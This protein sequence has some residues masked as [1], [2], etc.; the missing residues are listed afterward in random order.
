M[1]QLTSSNF[2]SWWRIL[3]CMGKTLVVEEE[4]WKCSKGM[5]WSFNR[6]FRYLF[7]ESRLP[8]KMFHNSKTISK[9]FPDKNW[10]LVLADS[11]GEI[12]MERAAEGGLCPF[13]DTWTH[14]DGSGEAQLE[15]DTGK[16]WQGPKMCWCKALV[17][18]S[19]AVR[20]LQMGEAMAKHTALSPMLLLFALDQ[21]WGCQQ[22]GATT[23]H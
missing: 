23:V 1:I 16:S 12:A 15:V 9:P 6:Q 3:D 20:R 5:S 7:K 17:G 13:K 11:V 10:K 18:L 14:R 4:N 2:S 19:S 22:T 8:C 21:L